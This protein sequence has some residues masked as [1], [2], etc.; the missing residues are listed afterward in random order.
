MDSITTSAPTSFPSV[1]RI[2]GGGQA[3]LPAVDD[4]V[5]PSDGDVAGKRPCTESYFQSM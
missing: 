4:E 3:D 5:L 1:R 2:L